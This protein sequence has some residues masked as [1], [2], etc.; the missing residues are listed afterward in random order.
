MW[1]DVALLK[2][3]VAQ[4]GTKLKDNLVGIAVTVTVSAL[5]ALFGYIFAHIPG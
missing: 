2:P 3:L 5:T 4:Y 1:G